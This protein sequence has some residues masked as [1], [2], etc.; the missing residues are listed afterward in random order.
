MCQT[1]NLTRAPTLTKP[2]ELFHIKKLP[3]LN[4]HKLYIHEI[5]TL[6]ARIYSCLLQSYHFYVANSN[7]KR[8]EIDNKLRSVTT[9]IPVLVARFKL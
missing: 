6:T 3:N 2:P 5:P 8:I 7:E 4:L 1:G 9:K